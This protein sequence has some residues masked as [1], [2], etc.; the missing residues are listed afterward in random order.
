MDH[1]NTLYRTYAS[2]KS[3]DGAAGPGDDTT[4]AVEVMRA[5]LKPRSMILEIGLGDGRFLDW[6]AREGP[7]IQRF[8]AARVNLRHGRLAEPCPVSP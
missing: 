1:R 3:W 4:Y 8:H 6:V 5:G 7:Q 2:F